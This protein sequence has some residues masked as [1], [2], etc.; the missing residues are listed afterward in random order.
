MNLRKKKKC[1]LCNLFTEGTVK[2]NGKIVCF[3]CLEKLSIHT[4]KTDTIKH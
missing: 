3:S 2:F 4:G 1:S